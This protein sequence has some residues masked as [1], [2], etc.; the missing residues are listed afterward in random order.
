[1]D[2]LR[3]AARTELTELGQKIEAATAATA[4]QLAQTCVENG[5]LEGAK[6]HLKCA[7]SSFKKSG[8]ID[9]PDLKM[10]T[11]INTAEAESAAQLQLKQRE[12]AARQDT[13]KLDTE[14]QA[15]GQRVQDEIDLERVLEEERA[16]DEMQLVHQALVM[17]D[18]GADSGDHQ[19]SIQQAQLFF[20]FRVY[21]SIFAKVINLAKQP[22]YIH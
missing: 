14:R 21:R 9:A 8:N 7:V 12:D 10:D 22:D 13:E 20:F 2:C 11:L 5:D 15:E 19:E 18:F 3:Q 1:M 17:E 16:A 6:P 4:I